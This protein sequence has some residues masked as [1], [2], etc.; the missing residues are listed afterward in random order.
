MVIIKSLL[1]PN[2]AREKRASMDFNHWAR[3]M[4][5]HHLK[6]FLP[7]DCN[8][9]SQFFFGH[10]LHDALTARS[11]FLS[12]VNCKFKFFRKFNNPFYCMHNLF[13]KS[14]KWCQLCTNVLTSALKFGLFDLISD[15]NPFY[16]LPSKHVSCLLSYGHVCLNW[17]F[18]PRMDEDLNFEIGKKR[19]MCVQLDFLVQFK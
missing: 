12:F 8:I 14:I 19:L 7:L 1:L 9:L 6:R 15:A 3:Q 16:G 13:K 10:S 18:K 2:C 17:I 11:G 5:V 4:A